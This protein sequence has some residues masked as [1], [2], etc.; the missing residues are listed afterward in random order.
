VKVLTL[1]KIASMVAAASVAM[2]VSAAD[3]TSVTKTA[4]E[5]N[6]EV[7]TQ[8]FKFL[9]ATANQKTAKAGYLPSV[10]LNAAYGKGDREFDSRGW[11][12]QGQVEVALTQV[13]FDGFRIKNKVEQGDYAALRNYYELNAG[14]EQKALE[15]AQ[16]YLDVQRYRELVKLAETNFNNHQRVY[17]QIQ[18]R[19]N[20]GVGNRADLAQIAGRL[21]LAQTN[22]MTEQSNLND[23][24]AR[25]A[26]IV[27]IEPAA[28]LAPVNVSATLPSSADAAIQQAYANN[29]SLKAALSEMQYAR[30]N[31]QE[32]KANMYPKLSFVART[33]LYQNRNSFD[34]RT[35]PDKYG[36]DSSAELRLNYNL[37]NGGADKAALNAAN[38]RVMLSDD[39]KN[40]ACVDIRQTTT[41]AYNNVNN[42][43]SQMQWL[44]R[45]RDESNAVVKAYADQ[46]DI[47]RRSLLDVL[48]SENEAFQANR[49]YANAQYDLKIAQLQTLYSTG[50]LLPALGVQRDNLPEV[51]SVSSREVVSENVC[52]NSAQAA[53]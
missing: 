10:D 13:L 38:A 46:F 17:N 43:N 53:E 32:Y 40:K 22:L 6:P 29:N 51:A 12:N 34:E 16:A 11:F 19:A 1:T 15:A 42:Y 28:N 5:N 45:H 24:S 26:R 4:I 31:S 7:Q 37:F 48:D 49:T 9:E 25:Y 8:W 27:G 3:L 39:L 30:A 23:V 36:Q 50:Q 21:S 47:G 52:A 35:N 33:G 44:Q 20:Q 14:V 18:Q 2:S 41:I